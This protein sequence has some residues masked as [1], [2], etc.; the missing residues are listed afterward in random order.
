V[1]YV[2]KNHVRHTVP[3]A[4]LYTVQTP[5]FFDLATLRFAY[6]KVSG[7]GRFTDDAALVEAAGIPIHVFKGDYDNIKVTHRQDIKRIFKLLQCEKS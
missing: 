4:H 7:N 1:K 6:N 5:Q 3:R 2:Q